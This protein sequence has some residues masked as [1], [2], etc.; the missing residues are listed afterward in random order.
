MTDQLPF[1]SSRTYTGLSSFS[2]S[3]GTI[4]RVHHLQLTRTTSVNKPI[5]CLYS[6]ADEGIFPSW[7]RPNKRFKP[8]NGDPA[9]CTLLCLFP[10]S[11][12]IKRLRVLER[13]KE[14]MQLP[15]Q[16]LGRL[17][18]LFTRYRIV[19]ETSS[20]EEAG[21]KKRQWEGL[22]HREMGDFKQALYYL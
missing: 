22:S 16:L 15:F 11:A 5:V 18:L 14:R 3:S 4:D 6:S 9:Y 20:C 7:Q 19:W 21:E 1:K 2:Q 8:V 17:R 10:S 12:F 13:A